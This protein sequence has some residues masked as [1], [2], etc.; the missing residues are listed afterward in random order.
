MVWELSGVSV[1]QQ[2]SFNLA[3][4]AGHNGPVLGPRCFGPENGSN[5]NIIPF[6]HSSVCT[7]FGTCLAFMLSGCSVPILPTAS[8][9]KHMT[10]TNCCIYTVVRPDDD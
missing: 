5:P 9:H 7:A 3:Y 4:N 10:Y 8:Q 1:T 2:G 6:V